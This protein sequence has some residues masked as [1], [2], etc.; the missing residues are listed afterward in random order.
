MKKEQAEKKQDNWKVR[1][2][3]F[4]YFHSLILTHLPQLVWPIQSTNFTLTF[5][6]LK[7]PCGMPTTVLLITNFLFSPV[8][9]FTLTH[10]DSPW[11]ACCFHMFYKCDQQYHQQLQMQHI[12][13]DTIHHE[14]KSSSS[15]ENRDERSGHSRIENWR[16]NSSAG[17]AIQSAGG[18]PITKS[19]NKL[20]CVCEREEKR[21]SGFGLS[22]IITHFLPVVH[23]LSLKLQLLWLG[24]ETR[25]SLNTMASIIS[26]LGRVLLVF[27]YFNLT[28]IDLIQWN[29]TFT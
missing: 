7:Q 26:S 24:K 25:A 15:K 18:L 20:D 2:R 23:H 14:K 5:R 16:K 8:S 1:S 27:L 9:P 6:W 12:V 19:L 28:L 22:I 3:D 17:W 13:H 10:H 21:I 11:K 29:K 4:L